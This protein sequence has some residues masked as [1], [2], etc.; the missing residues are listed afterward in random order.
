VRFGYMK[1]EFHVMNILI[2]FELIPSF[3][4]GQLVH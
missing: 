3:H 2:I 4:F 1:D